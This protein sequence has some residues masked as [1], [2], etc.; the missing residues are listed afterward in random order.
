MVV[1][2]TESHHSWIDRGR[3]V[4]FWAVME[5]VFV[6]PALPLVLGGGD[7]DGGVLRT[8]DGHRGAPPAGA[9]VEAAIVGVVGGS[10]EGGGHTQHRGT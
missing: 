7:G 3:N 6:R 10:P 5:K 8:A 1:Q 2:V 9:G 4:T